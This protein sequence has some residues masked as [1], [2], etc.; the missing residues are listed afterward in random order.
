MSPA[1][2][3][4]VLRRLR[5]SG[6]G[7][8]PALGVVAALAAGA[9]ALAPAASATESYGRP[10]G[11]TITLA[12]HGYGHGHGMSQYGAWGAADRGL[13]W[14][15]VM[16]FY[17]PG[18]ALGTYGNPTIRVQ[19]RVLGSTDT[20]AVVVP[21][22][23][24]ASPTRTIVLPDHAGSTPIAA[25]RVTTASGGG[26]FLLQW[27][28]ATS[29]WTTDGAFRNTTDP[30][31]FTNDAALVRVVL[32]SGSLRDYRGSVTATLSGTGM[33]S[34][35][36]VP[37]DTYLASVVPSE[38]PASWPAAAL[39]AQAV[40]ARS[41]AAFDI[42]AKTSSAIYDT[43]DTTS[44]QMYSGVADYSASGTRTATHEYA[45]STSAVAD[46]AHGV[47]LYAGKP[48]FT[49][50][51]ASNGGWMAAGSQ[52]YLVAKVD[53]YDGVHPSSAHDWTAS[54]TV[55][56]M[57]SAFASTGTF[58]RLELTR[59]DGNGDWGGRAVS[60]TV[61][62]SAGS[63]TVSGDTFRSR[64]GLRSEWFVPTSAPAVSSPAFPR[65][66][67]DDGAAD[68][69]VVD[70]SGRLKVFAGTGSSGFAAPLTAGGGWSGLTMVRAVGPF[71]ADN[72]G[73]LV[74]RRTDGTLWLYPGSST[75]VFHQA[76]QRIGAGWNALDTVLAP[77][78]WDGDHH[79]DLMGRQPSTGRLWLYPGTGA[80]QI[81]Q[82]R[83]VG[84]GWNGMRQILATGDI[85][86]D[87][88]PDVLALKA[89]NNILYVYPGNGSGGWLAP[90]VVT[91]GWG[92]FDQ[93]VGVGDVTGDG[94]GDLLAR[95]KSDGAMVLYPGTGTG[96]VTSGRV[97]LTG[98]GAYPTVVP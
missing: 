5:P 91:A 90:T 96:R 30:L 49:Q 46:T 71:D 2:D 94:K 56:S 17:Y 20:E 36:R 35:N 98:W 82:P 67:T 38:M 37:M 7:R 83:V 8:R 52:P 88:K 9:V 4:H 95:R 3:R 59:R 27:R 93:L 12:G 72:R 84:T 66:L 44:C 45:S 24:I 18:T 42:A 15:Q 47:V 73:D 53:P 19:L 57:Q 40:A 26:A 81:G 48:A 78:D 34:V 51:S 69:T 23:T 79:N 25:W 13:S 11:S 32:P 60:V 22:L 28:S 89:S 43:C 86:G 97:V 55:A 21:G 74:G 41:Y 87:G 39:R 29:G 61:V 80:G 1:R 77:G 64:F 65:D 16:A 76:P 31:T 10:A 85:T 6:P 54:I 68:L 70:A 92:G 50:F 75:G 63:S 62:G 14:Q 33:T 58:Q